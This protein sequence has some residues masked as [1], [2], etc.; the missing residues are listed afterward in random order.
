MEEFQNLNVNIDVNKNQ[1][2]IYLGKCFR[3]FCNE[4]GW[5]IFIGSIIITLLIGSVTGENMFSDYK[6]T[7]YGVFAL[8]C[9]CIWTGIFNSI[10]SI[11]KER[12]II[13]REYMSGLSIESY[14]IA[15]LI[16]EFMLCA[17]EAFLVTIIVIFKNES[18]ML[19]SGVICPIQLELYL[20]FFLIIFSSDVLA[21]MVSCIVKTTNTAMTVMPFIL[22]IQLVMSG[23]IFELE[24]ISKFISNFTISKWGLAAILTTSNLN[25]MG[26]EQLFCED[27]EYT[28]MNLLQNWMLLLVFCLVYACIGILFLKR[29]D[30]DKR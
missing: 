23:L 27:Y 12:D 7:K 5:K 24:G 26:G 30:K 17:V 6:D 18:T 2:R 15:H 20:S 10:Q 14:I 28:V 16:Y 21:L 13:K 25:E 9:A 19:D 8:S 11:C 22:I 4:K 29:V 3:I 1:V